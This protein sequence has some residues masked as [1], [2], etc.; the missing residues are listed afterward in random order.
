MLANY[1]IQKRWHV[2]E[3]VKNNPK[4]MLVKAPNGKTIKRHK[5]KHGAVV[6]K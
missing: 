2:G 6:A 3:I 5:I 1:R 4:T